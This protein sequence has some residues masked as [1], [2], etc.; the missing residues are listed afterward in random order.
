MGSSV[1]RS[2]GKAKNREKSCMFFQNRKLFELNHAYSDSHG[3]RNIVQLSGVRVIGI[4]VELQLSL[5]LLIGNRVFTALAQP[6]I[7]FVLKF[8]LKDPVGKYV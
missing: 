7:I 8:S 2:V 1:I 4:G 6:T 3:K 5:L